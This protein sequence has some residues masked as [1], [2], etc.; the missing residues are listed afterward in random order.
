MGFDEISAG[1]IVYRILDS[2]PEYLILKH[3]KGLHWGFPKGKIEYETVVDAAKREFE[4]ET[5]ISPKAL[6]LHTETL[7]HETYDY[8]ENN[9]I[10]HKKVTY[11]LA[12]LTEHHEIYLSQEHT[13]FYWGDLENC[14]DKIE[15][16]DMKELLNRVDELV[17]SRL[18]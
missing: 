8:L 7:F 3:S 11:L 13:M 1:I 17:K 15:F 16:D 4:E 14:F 9:Q 6:I 2:I 18:S 5:G 10:K 12:E